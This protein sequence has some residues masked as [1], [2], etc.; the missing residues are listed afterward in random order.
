MSSL[1]IYKMGATVK[2]ESDEFSVGRQKIVNSL[3]ISTSS[4]AESRSYQCNVYYLVLDTQNLENAPPPFKVAAHATTALLLA[5]LRVS[6]MRQ[7]ACSVS[8]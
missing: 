4:T 6:E 8:F 3:Q 1:Q 2:T 7:P 5:L